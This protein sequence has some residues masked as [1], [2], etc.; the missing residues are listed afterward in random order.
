MNNLI[1][2]IYF[3]YNVFLRLEEDVVVLE[4]IEFCFFG[5]FKLIDSLVKVVMFNFL[6]VLY[7]YMLIKLILNLFKYNLVEIYV[8]I[9]LNEKVW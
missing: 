3:N 5:R 7:V 8:Y 1:L 2:I 6:K 9:F 4:R